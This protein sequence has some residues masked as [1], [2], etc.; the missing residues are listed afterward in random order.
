MTET[1]ITLGRG[2]ARLAI[3]TDPPEASPAAEPLGVILLNAG[4]IHHVGPSRL[5]VRLAR[6]LAM[7]GHVALRLDYS[8]VG[9]SRPREDHLPAEKSVIQEALQAMD[10]LA[11]LRGVTRFVLMGHCSGAVHAFQTATQDDRVA[12]IVLINLEGG[13]SEWVT[14]D[15]DR[16]AARYYSAYYGERARDP[17]RWRRLLTGQANYRKIAGVIFGTLI[18]NR[19][20]ALA[21][22]VSNRA[23]RPEPSQLP[24]LVVQSRTEFDALIARGTRVLFAHSE[25]STGLEYVRFTLGEHLEKAIAGGTANLEIIPQSDHLFTVLRAQSEL[26]AVI[27]SWLARVSQN[28]P[29]NE[30]AGA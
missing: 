8:G 22:R 25:G 4:L 13:E 10:R 15:R 3:L 28:L 18:V 30:G 27:E 23:R 7:A 24:P 9:D 11:S 1:V 20:K 29:A 16:K 26:M 5:Y 2:G 14:Y 12:A 21:F 19:V 6:R 17:D